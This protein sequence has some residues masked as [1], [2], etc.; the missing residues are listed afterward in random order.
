MRTQ[1]LLRSVAYAS[2]LEMFANSAYAAGFKVSSATLEANPE[3]LAAKLV[4]D[5]PVAVTAW[6]IDILVT[7]NGP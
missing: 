2:L 6:G 4:N 7:R 3:R 5:S 1:L